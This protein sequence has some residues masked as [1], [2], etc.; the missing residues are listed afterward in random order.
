MENTIILS[1]MFPICRVKTCIYVHGVVILQSKKISLLAALV[2]FECIN[3][4]ITVCHADCRVY[5]EGR[6]TSQVGSAIRP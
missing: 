2:G 6:T 1:L 4:L 5:V 3:H